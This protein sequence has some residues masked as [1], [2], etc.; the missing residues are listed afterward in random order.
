MSQTICNSQSIPYWRE[1]GWQP[2]RLTWEWFSR[3]LRELDVGGPAM[4]LPR[5]VV[6]HKTKM[7]AMARRSLR[8][9]RMARHG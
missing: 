8:I 6:K 9:N 4:D 3:E 2:T 5:R 7:R 1:S